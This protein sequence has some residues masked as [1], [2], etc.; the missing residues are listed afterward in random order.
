MHVN[1]LEACHHRSIMEVIPA[2]DVLDGRIVRLHQGRY[3]RATAYGDDPA[4]QVRRFAADG[5]E[6]VHVVDLSA[7]RSGLPT[8]ELWESLVGAGVAI[9][10]GGGIRTAETASVLVE[11]GVARCVIGTAALSPDGPLPDIISAVG[12]EAV[13][14]GLDV[15][16]GRAR[17]SGWT[18]MGRPLADVVHWI[19][20]CGA[21]RALVTGIDTDGTMGGPDH[22]LLA[23]V[24]ELAPD[25]AILASGGVGTLEDI[26]ALARNGWEAAIVGKALYEGAFTLTEARQRAQTDDGSA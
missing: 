3:D 21:V 22:A 7:A 13:V 24:A 18:D 14:V 23:R 11:R 10:A 8:L 1:L 9:Q 2:V 25:V 16:D 17:G 19:V 20:S 15:R 4:A 6:V 12:P 26:A 5:A